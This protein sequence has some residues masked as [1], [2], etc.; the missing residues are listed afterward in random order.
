MV[1]P[2]LLLKKK[3]PPIK[4]TWVIGQDVNVFYQTHVNPCFY[5]P[6]AE[7]E[8]KILKKD[9][10]I[11]IL[12]GD[13][14]LLLR[15][16]FK[17]KV[18]VREDQK[19]VNK[20]IRRNESLS[21]Q[22]QSSTRDL[23]KQLGHSNELDSDNSQEQ[24]QKKKKK[25]E[26][27]DDEP[28]GLNKHSTNKLGLWYQQ[29][30]PCEKQQVFDNKTD[31]QVSMESNSG[32]QPLP[33]EEN[34]PQLSAEKQSMSVSTSNMKKDS[35]FSE[36]K[37]SSFYPQNKTSTLGCS[38]KNKIVS[39]PE[40]KPS[41][42]RK[43]TLPSWLVKAATS[44]GTQKP[45][46]ES[47]GFTVSDEDREGKKC[48]KKRRDSAHDLEF[49]NKG[50]EGSREYDSRSDSDGSQEPYKNSILTIKGRPDSDEEESTDE[51]LRKSCRFGE[52]CYRKNPSHFEEFSHPGDRDFL[53]AEDASS[54]NEEKKPECQ[55]GVDCY[56]KNLK[57][58]QKYSHTIKMRPKREAA[59]K[60]NQKRKAE[61]EDSDSFIDDSDVYEPSDSD[62]DWN[63]EKESVEDISRLVKEAKGFMK[64]KR[65]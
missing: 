60:G 58:R 41:F 64:N 15:D 8:V 27:N 22:F 47:D 62:S 57:H 4:S 14:F 20:K 48:V 52:K 16:S 31:V 63:P 26:K 38:P 50:K 35:V 9:D 21:D 59:K 17:F 3:G 51:K 13:A 45:V 19:D 65:L 49:E 33:V 46:P 2:S 56:R 29:D 43:R 44:S 54:D 32:P 10:R 6:Q 23:S 53:E 11:E 34:T 30:K 42:K 1:I 39:P 28:N 40:E 7:G 25:T 55:Y 37:S 36:K 12:P 18:I 61:N 24:K 5:Q